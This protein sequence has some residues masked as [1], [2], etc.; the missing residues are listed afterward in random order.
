M[1]VVPQ[2]VGGVKPLI[3]VVDDSLSLRLPQEH[4]RVLVHPRADD[5]VARVLVV[6]HRAEVD[7]PEGVHPAVLLAGVH[8]EVAAHELVEVRLPGAD[9]TEQELG[10]IFGT[11]SARAGLHF[12]YKLVDRFVDLAA[13][14]GVLAV[15]ERVFSGE[16]ISNDDAIEPLVFSF[17]AS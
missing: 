16:H 11:E 5:V 4:E 10:P 1:L 14:E 2:R 7:P 9:G 17:T 6:D 12:V 8:L 15:V 13:G 3:G